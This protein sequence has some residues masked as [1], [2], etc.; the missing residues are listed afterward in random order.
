MTCRLNPARGV[1]WSGL[2]LSLTPHHHMPVWCMGWNWCYRC[3]TW[4]RAHT[5]CCTLPDQCWSGSGQAA[6]S[7]QDQSGGAPCAAHTPC[8]APVLLA[9]RAA[10]PA[11]CV[12]SEALPAPLWGLHCRQCIGPARCLARPAMCTPH[13]RTV[14]PMLLHTPSCLWGSRHRFQAMRCLTPFPLAPG[15]MSLT[16]LC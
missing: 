11:P 3:C 16:P 10:S 5:A 13:A 4:L 6:A 9:A 12:L 7:T 15:Q 14:H 8:W 2:C 1:I